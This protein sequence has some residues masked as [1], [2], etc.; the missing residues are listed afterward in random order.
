MDKKDNKNISYLSFRLGDEV[1]ALHVGKVYKIL[2]MTPVTEVP[3]SPDYMK[4]VINLRGKVLPVIDTRIKFGMSPTETTKSTCLL[5]IDAEIGEETVMV[6]MLV[7]AVQAVM[8]IEDDKILPPPS[9][10]NRYQSDF[11]LGMTKV[12]EKFVMVLNIDAVLTSDDLIDL[13]AINAARQTAE[14]EEAATN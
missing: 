8:K 13:K 6:S 2:E 7:D 9:I 14:K 11:I 3:R 10:G 1:F 4:G 5:V 12:D